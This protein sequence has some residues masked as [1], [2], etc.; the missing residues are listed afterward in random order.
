[1]R[2]GGARVGVTLRHSLPENLTT[3]TQLLTWGVTVGLGAY[4]LRVAPKSQYVGDSTA[5][6]SQPASQRL[7]TRQADSRGRDSQPTDR[8][9]AQPLT[10]CS[11]NAVCMCRTQTL[12]STEK[13][14]AHKKAIAQVVTGH[15]RAT[16]KNGSSSR[17]SSEDEEGTAGDSTVAAML[18]QVLYLALVTGRKW[19]QFEFHHGDEEDDLDGSLTMGP[20]TVSEEDWVPAAASRGEQHTNGGPPEAS[21]N[22]K[23]K[24]TALDDS[25]R[26]QKPCQ[27]STASPPKSKAS[28]LNGHKP[29]DV[30]SKQLDNNLESKAL[31]PDKAMTNEEMHAAIRRLRQEVAFWKAKAVAAGVDVDE[32]GQA[33]HGK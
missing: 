26:T 2:L 20:I 18:Q 3:A 27:G 25:N 32:A 14:F 1:M 31:E 5:Q 29:A 19:I 30:S 16:G 13:F 23:Y 6:V 21:A 9:G 17:R 12:Y 8:H 7:M 10:S 33:F 15:L 24:P 22:G 4:Q 11:V 28:A